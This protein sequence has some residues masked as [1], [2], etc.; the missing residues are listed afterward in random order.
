MNL[1]FSGASLVAELL[2]QLKENNH[3]REAMRSMLPTGTKEVELKE[4]LH[5]VLRTYTRMR[6]KYYVRRDVSCRD[7][8][9]PWKV[10]IYA[11]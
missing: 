1:L 5:Y 9:H 11:P 3:I 10:K 6:G 2:R 4:V 8:R 7:Q